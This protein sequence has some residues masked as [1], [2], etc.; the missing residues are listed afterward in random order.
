M[1]F[2]TVG[3]EH[4]PPGKGFKESSEFSLLKN[5]SRCT[6][7]DKDKLA[8]SINYESNREVLVVVVQ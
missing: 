8:I 2:G 1:K 4:P 5:S 3:L 7:I 6:N